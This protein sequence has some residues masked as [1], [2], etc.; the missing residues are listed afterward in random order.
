MVLSYLST[1]DEPGIQFGRVG[2]HVASQISII[3]SCDYFDGRTSSPVSPAN[4]ANTGIVMYR[5]MMEESNCDEWSH[6]LMVLPST[7][8]RSHVIKKGL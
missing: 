7:D 1:N 3:F 4:T 6:Q 5:R 8:G 2:F